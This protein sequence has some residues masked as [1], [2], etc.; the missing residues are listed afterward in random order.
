M[1][2]R[3]YSE[4]ADVKERLVYNLLRS[5]LIPP[6]VEKKA[7]GMTRQDVYYYIGRMAKRFNLKDWVF[8]YMAMAGG[9]RFNSDE[10]FEL[11]RQKKIYPNF[12]RGYS[13][14]KHENF[15]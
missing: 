11:V 1:R 8:C 7:P 2:K 15:L 12:I 14:R 3:C 5:G 10:A 13:P 4:M 6:Q 9:S